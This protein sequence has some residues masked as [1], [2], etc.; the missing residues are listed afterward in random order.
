[1]TPFQ[2]CIMFILILLLLN[3]IGIKYKTTKED[4]ECI[5][6]KIND[7]YRNLSEKEMWEL[8]QEDQLRVIQQLEE[9][10][11]KI[12]E[13]EIKTRELSNKIIKM[14]EGM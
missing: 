6:E 7:K 12:T 10:S 13:E 9:L 1:M 3:V 11:R 4:E 8:I 2:F 14:K 5:N